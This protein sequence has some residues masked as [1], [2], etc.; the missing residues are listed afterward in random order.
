MADISITATNVISTTGAVYGSGT[1]GAA[2]TAG[3]ALYLDSNTN[4]LKLAITT[5]AAAADA[6]G[7]ALHAAG[8]GQPMK[9]QTAGDITIGGT[10]VAG[11]T[12]VTSTTAGGIA[13]V[14][15]AT[16][17]QFTKILIMG[18]TTA[19]ATILNVGPSTIVAHG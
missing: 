15:D 13:P 7:I 12:Y 8:S 6:V 17:G 14:T 2:V 11:Q 10:I 3:Q 16:A 9:Y 4:T 5:S 1:T 18:R 19:I